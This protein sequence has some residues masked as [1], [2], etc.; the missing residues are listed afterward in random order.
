MPENNKTDSELQES[1]DTITV[2]DM[3]HV[4]AVAIGRHAKVEYTE[5]V[6]D[7]E[8]VQSY[9]DEKFREMGLDGLTIEQLAQMEPSTENQ[10][11]IAELEELVA[12]SKAQGTAM[13]AET[14]Y[15]LGKI[16][17]YRGE[18]QQ[19]VD[20]FDQA[21]KLDPT[22]SDSLFMISWMAH[23]EALSELS[24]RR[25]DFQAALDSLRKARETAVQLMA[26]KAGDTQALGQLAYC[27]KTRAQIAERTQD[28]ENL[29]KYANEA[30]GLFQQLL[31][32]NPRDAGAHNGLANILLM[33]GHDDEAIAYGRQAIALRWDY[34]AAYFDLG[35]AYS[36]KLYGM[37]QAE[38][39]YDWYETAVLVLDQAYDLAESSLDAAY[40]KES[41]RQVRRMLR[42]LKR[43]WR[44]HKLVY[45]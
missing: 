44:W 4:K 7:P 9:V 36:R 26:L 6:Q 17:A 35:I 24:K 41:Q 16:A 27:A 25:P 18:R 2:G 14:A 19:A 3:H 10:Q 31:A 11:I 38:E 43:L 23:N 8:L 21:F 42:D 5:I 15:I 45:G 34:Q 39:W 28:R 22:R 33:Q 1:G 13:T 37:G 30:S 29:L 20:Y 40:K 32:L 12:E